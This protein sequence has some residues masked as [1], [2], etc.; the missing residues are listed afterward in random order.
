MMEYAAKFNKVSLFAL[1]QLATNEMKMDHFEQGLK[2]S[3]KSTIAGHS[4][5][6]FK[7]ICQRV[8]KIARVVEETER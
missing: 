5:E 6:N 3:I 2:G 1:H 4:F 8:V 7:K